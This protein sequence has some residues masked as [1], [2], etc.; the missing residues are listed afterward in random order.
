LRKGIDKVGD[1]GGVDPL[2]RV[3]RSER[4]ISEK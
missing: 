1:D 2:D 4:R 3:L